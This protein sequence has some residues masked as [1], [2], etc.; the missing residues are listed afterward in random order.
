MTLIAFPFFIAYV[1][2]SSALCWHDA[3]TGLLPD[4]LTCPLLWAGLLFQL[5]LR[6]A[7]VNDALW[8]IFA[9]YGAM[10]MIYWG[11]RGLR[12]REGLG[13]G[14]V[15]YLAALG[16]WHG[17]PSLPVLVLTASTMAAIYVFSTAC[18]QRS[19]AGIKNPLPFGPFLGAAGFIVAGVSGFNLR[20]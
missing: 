19:L 7:N 2:L 1:L 13:Y 6:P 10:A 16:A 5:S 11:Y 17:W 14:D 3:R 4:R 9:G 18:W 12:G 15:K 20:L 8:G